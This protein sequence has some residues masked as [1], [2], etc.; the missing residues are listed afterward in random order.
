M[1]DVGLLCGALTGSQGVDS[2]YSIV[3]MP[4]GVPVAT[5]AI[6]NA[7]NAGLLAVRQPAAA[8]LSRQLWGAGAPNIDAMCLSLTLWF[9]SG[10]DARRDATGA[11]RQDDG[12]P[13]G[14][15]RHGRGQGREADE[16]GL[17]GVLRGDGQ[18]VFH[19]H[20]DSQA[21]FRLRS[22]H[23]EAPSH[24]VVSAPVAIAPSA[25]ESAV[26][27]PLVVAIETRQ[28]HRL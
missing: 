10:T 25:S 4:R 18:Q 5:V 13:G 15:W 11:K 17:R 27:S 3:Q 19:G 7:E 24:H 20:V 23:C 12:I 8:T 22:K 6:G 26:E 2:L 28:E 1:A 16:R 9:D 14:G 21:F